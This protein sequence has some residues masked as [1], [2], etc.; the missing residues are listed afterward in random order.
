MKKGAKNAAWYIALIIISAFIIFPIY[1]LFLIAVA[2]TSEIFRASPALIPSSISFS[3]FVFVLKNYPVLTSLDM[4]LETA[5]VVTGICLLFGIPASYTISK[6]PGKLAYFVVIFLFVTEMVPEIQIAVPIAS[7]MSSLH[8]IN[9]PVGIGLA[10][11]AIILPMTTYIM[12]GTFKTIPPRLR[13]SAMIDG[14]SKLKSFASVELP[15]ALTG[16]SVAAILAWMFSWDEFVLASIIS[17]AVKTLPVAIYYYS[18][19]RGAGG[20]PVVDAFSILMIIPVIVIVLLLQKYI[21]SD[22]LAGALK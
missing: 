6:L 4:S 14:A 7:T 16:I 10:Q 20:L 13:E 22:V 9:N 12:V 1:L 2:P 11:S 5:F 3:S 21:R 18:S 17:P 15:L 19:G 8:L